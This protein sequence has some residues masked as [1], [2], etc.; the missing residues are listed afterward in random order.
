MTKQTTGL[1][2]LNKR[3]GGDIVRMGISGRAV[4]LGGRVRKRV[5]VK[6]ERSIRHPGICVIFT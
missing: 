5:H 6:G 3:E 2:G 4:T 1:V